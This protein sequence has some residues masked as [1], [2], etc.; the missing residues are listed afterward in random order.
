MRAGIR[1]ILGPID[2]EP[3][4]ATVWHLWTVVVPRRSL[5]GCLVWGRVWRRYDGRGWIYKQFVEYS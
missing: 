5:A 3:A 4:W 1:E 2:P